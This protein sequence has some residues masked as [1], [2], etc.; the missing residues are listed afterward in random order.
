MRHF[1]HNVGRQLA[2]MVI[3]VPH[4]IFERNCNHL[5][6]DHTV[7]DHRYYADRV[8][9]DKSERRNNLAANHKDVQRIV[10]VA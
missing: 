1:V 9:P 6:V 2:D 5:M 10:I 4:R 8:A 7:V 3:S